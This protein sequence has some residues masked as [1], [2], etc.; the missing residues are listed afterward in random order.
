M[1]TARTLSQPSSE[2][3]QGKLNRWRTIMLSAARQSKR[4]YLPQLHEPL[5]FKKVTALQCFDLKL[6][7]YE[8]SESAPRVHCSGKNILFL[9]GG[10]GGFTSAEI[11]EARV[12][13]FSEISLGKTILR[14]ETAGIF[15][16]AFVRTQLL[17]EECVEWF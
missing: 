13:G 12:A 17:E 4:H 15:A 8:L 10:E 5:S 11:E 3:V 16:V 6:I 7:P 2:K 14:A 9:I 1:I